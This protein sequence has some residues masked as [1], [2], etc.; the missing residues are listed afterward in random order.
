MG[1][2]SAAWDWDSSTCGGRGSVLV[3][4]RKGPWILVLFAF[5]LRVIFTPKLDLSNSGQEEFQ[6]HEF[7]GYGPKTS[8]N[9]SEDISNEVKES[10]DALSIKELVSDD[11]LEKK[12]VFPIG[13]P[14]LELQEK[15]VIDSGCS[16][17]MTG[18]MS[19]LSEYKE[20]TGGYLPL[21][22]TP[23][24]VKSLVKIKSV[25]LLDE[26]QVLL[27]VPRKNNMYSVDLKNVAPSGGLT[28]LF[29]KA[30]LDESIH[31]H[32]RL[33][34]INFKTMNKLNKEI[35]QLC[36]EKGIK[37]EFSVARNL[38]QNRVA[39]RKNRTLIEAARTMLADSKLTTTIWAEAVNTAC[40]VQN[41]VLVSKPH[42]KT[43]YELFNDR[44]PSL[45]FML[46]FGCLVTILNTLD[47]LGKFDGKAN[48]GF[49]VGY[50]V[51][52]K[53]F[54]EFNSRT[55]IV[56]E[57]LHI[58]FLEN[59]PNVAGSGPNWLF[60]IGTMKKFMNYKPVVTGN[61]SN[62][63]ASKA[64]VETVPEKDYIL[65]PL[66]TQDPL[67]FSSSKDFISAGYKPL[68]EE[69]KK[70]VEDLRNIDSKVP[71]TE[72]PIINQEKDANINSTSNINVFSPIINAVDIEDN[73]VDEN[74]VFGC[75][76][77]PNIPNLE[78]IVYLDDDDEEVVYQMDVKSAFLYGR[79][80]E[81]VYVCQPLGFENPEF[82]DRVYKVEKALYGLHQAPR[83][84]YET[85]ST[86]LLD[87]RFHR[88]NEEEQIQAIVDKK[89]V[90][91]TATSLRSDLQLEDDEG[92]ECLLNATIFEQ[93]TLM[94]AKCTAWKE[95]SSTMA[96]VIICLATNLK[97]NFKYIFDNMV[98]NLDGG[99]KF[100]MFP[101]FVQ[102]FL[103]KQVEG[104][105]KHK[106]IYVTPS[107]TKKVVADEAVYKEMYGG[108]ERAATTAAGLDAEQDRD[109]IS[110]SR[111]IESSNKASLDDQ[112]DASK[113]GRIIDNLDADEGVSTSD[114]VTTA[115][116]VVSTVGVEVSAASTTLIISMDDITLAKALA[117]L[118]S[119]KPM[120]KE[121]SV[122]KAK[123]IVMQEPEGTPIRTKIV[124]SHSSKDKGNAKMIELEKTLKKKD[125]IMID[126]DV[127]RNL[128]AQLQAELEEE[129]RLARQKEEE[130]EN[131][132]LIAEWDDVQAMMDVD[133]NLAK[134]LQA[135]EQD[136]EVAEASETRGEGSSKRAGEELESNKSKKQK[137]DEKVEVEAYND[138]EEAEVKMYMKIVYDDDVAI[139]VIPLASKPLIIVDW[140]LIKE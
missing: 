30:T 96:S 16:S 60:N 5:F 25:Q 106:E 139:D 45:N 65:L 100:F 40:Y 76:D 118:K 74:I 66:W 94:S 34:H 32:K 24:E 4:F 103:D 116:E 127:S 87:N 20:I 132:A 117:A 99:V 123:G 126:E 57:T 6:Q 131:I 138:Q 68:G 21:K 105:F 48:E 110:S 36:E 67:F 101:R 93:L 71:N 31:W 38:Q 1:L 18:N 80:E 62:G 69:E 136:K 12:T 9:V 81:E 108:V 112:E 29:A 53:A 111:R 46:P 115:G 56:E 104:M 43:R 3:L 72:E 39:E 26:S 102:L 58:I 89:K 125:Q 83:A 11:K 54:R 14:Q 122:P 51:N 114:P 22:E 37:R 64:R 2:E 124:P 140:K 121:P 92:T 17:H 84:W 134:R 119:A 7:V 23:K 90:I 33:G 41:R 10:L 70:D 129:E 79:I 107:H 44:T 28:C 135:E 50:F 120:V 95:F 55:M 59:K 91:I 128:K 61:Q 130:E 47:T 98:K 63:S 75:A 49:F 109:I 35:N 88:A 85:L 97:F 86:Y 133:H 27:R 52:S 82:P 13:N 113:Q 19:Y 73:D 42:N 137:L 77:D 8:N 78:E 15:G